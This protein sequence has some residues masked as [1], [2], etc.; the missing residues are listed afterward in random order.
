MIQR[1]EFLVGL[2][3]AP[4]IVHSEN[5]MKIWVPKMEVAVVGYFYGFSALELEKVRVMHQKLWPRTDIVI[6]S[7]NGF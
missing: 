2:F 7:L 3:L 5:L 4:A 6:H 1:R